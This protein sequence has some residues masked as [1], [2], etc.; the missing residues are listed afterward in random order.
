MLPGGMPVPRTQ[1]SSLGRVGHAYALTVE[2][3]ARATACDEFFASHRINDDPMFVVQPFHD[4][5]GHRKV[6]DTLQIVQGAVQW[7]YDPREFGIAGLFA[8]FLCQNS[9]I[10]VGFTYLF[11]D[12]RFGVTIDVRDKIVAPLFLDFEL[13]RSIHATC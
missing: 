11:D 10:W 1:S 5:D 4:A 3:R 13:V 8:G 12:N 2:L 9:V 6:R 7:V